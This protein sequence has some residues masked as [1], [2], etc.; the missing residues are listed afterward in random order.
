MARSA[1]IFAVAAAALLSGCGEKVIDT[2]KIEDTLQQNLETSRKEGVSSVDCPSDQKVEPKATF[3]C[4]VKLKDGK[5]ETATL[6]IR[7]DQ[8]DVSVIDLREEGRGTNE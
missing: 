7:N 1:A 6:E 5:T 3:T 8:A 4:T 2:S